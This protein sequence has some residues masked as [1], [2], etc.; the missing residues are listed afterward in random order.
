MGWNCW[1]LRITHTWRWPGTSRDRRPEDIRPF[2]A[3]AEQVVLGAFRLPG[4]FSVRNFIR[5]KG[6]RAV[7]QYDIASGA[8]CS[9][10]IAF[11]LTWPSKASAWAVPV[12]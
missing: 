3:D 11:L 10:C 7:H 9:R 8:A 2:S 1:T 6:G 12:T 5:G 4:A